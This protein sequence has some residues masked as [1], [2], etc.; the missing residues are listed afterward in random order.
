MRILEISRTHIIIP[1][2]V[3]SRAYI[4]T[5]L[6]GISCSFILSKALAEYIVIAVTEI[7]LYSSKMTR[8]RLMTPIT[9]ELHAASTTTEENLCLKKR[10]AGRHHFAV[11]LESP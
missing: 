2:P 11:S 3:T 9:N 4:D 7:A 1:D 6:R 5:S 8:A 10:M